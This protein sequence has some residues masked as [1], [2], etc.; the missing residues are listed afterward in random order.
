MP[1]WRARAANIALDVLREHGRRQTERHRVDLAIAC[2]RDWNGITDS[3]GRRSFAHDFHVTPVPVR[4]S[5]EDRAVPAAAL[6][7][8]GPS[9]TA[10]TTQ[11]S[12]RWASASLII[13]P[14]TVC[15]VARVAD[16]HLACGIDHSVV[17]DIHTASWTNRRWSE[18]HTDRRAESGIDASR[19][20]PFQVG[21]VAD[22]VAE[23]LPSSRVT[24][25]SPHRSLE[26]P[27]QPRCCR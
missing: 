1:P 11:C 10:S 9:R 7:H 2:S 20:R 13:G 24:G 3:T 16:L 27:S 19:R 21:V 6:H 5:F 8:G 12:A 4:W 17:K 25:R 15:G 22:E 26:Q 23:M 18:V 14:T